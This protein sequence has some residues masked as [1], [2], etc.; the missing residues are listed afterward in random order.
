MKAV[1]VAIVALAIVAG[2]VVIEVLP[3]LDMMIAKARV[4]IFKQ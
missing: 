1:S 3:P 4:G 2:F